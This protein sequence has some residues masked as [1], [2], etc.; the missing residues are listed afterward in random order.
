MNK[1]YFNQIGSKID[2]L[3]SKVDKI[4]NQMPSIPEQIRQF[5]QLRQDG[6][7]TQEEF[8]EQKARLLQSTKHGGWEYPKTSDSIHQAKQQ[9]Q[10]VASEELSGVPAMEEF[11]R[12]VLQ[13]ASKQPGEFKSREAIDAMAHHFD[14]STE[15]GSDI[16]IR[17]EIEARSHTTWSISHLKY[18]GLLIRKGKAIYEI[19]DA[20]KKE[21]TSSNELITIDYLK[22]NFP[23]YQ[24]KRDEASGKNKN[25]SGEKSEVPTMD[26]FMSPILGYG[27]QCSGSF[28]LREVAD[29]MADYFNLSE[30]A[31]NE[32]TD[33]G[34]IDRVY[35][36]TSWAITHLKKAEFLRQ[37][38][39]GC[40]EITD[41]GRE[42]LLSSHKITTSYLTQNV[43]AYQRWKLSK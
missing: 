5:W 11:I 35:D 2:N 39:R 32:L 24:T 43:P 28:K 7:L 41:A 8:D 13:W 18:A 20:G 22:D 31:R 34:N 38:G 21:A 10:S 3:S 29:A 19:T 15:A 16:E 40:Y 1:N 26:D 30:E 12:P 42:A 9:Y 4:I 33:G 27:N 37:T 14:I 17:R 6:A 23:S 36:R 25:Q